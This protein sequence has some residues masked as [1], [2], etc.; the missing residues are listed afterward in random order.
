[1][2][3]IISEK[4]SEKIIILKLLKKL[5]L[6]KIG[7][8]NFEN[9]A[10]Y[11]TTTKNYKMIVTTDTIIEN[12]DFFFKDPPE[13]VAQKLVCVNLSDLAAMGSLP[14]A[15]TL[16][17]SL[18]SRIDLN[19]LKK[20]TKKLFF[21]QK[22][23]NIYLIGGDISKSKELNLSATFFGEAKLNNILS[24]NKCFVGQDIWV[25]GNLGNSYLGFKL[26]KNLKLKINK[27]DKGFFIKSYLYPNPCMFG[28]IASK[29]MSA[30]IDISDGF[31]GNLNKILN[32]KIGANINLK[33]IPIS[34]NLKRV[35]NENSSKIKMNDIINGGDDYQLIFTS[36]KKFKNKL[37]NLAKKNNIKL[38]KIGSIIKE[39]GVFD[40]SINLIKNVS[41]FDHFS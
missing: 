35:I 21:F 12:V 5:N 33:K 30:A 10:S 13:S 20:L 7:T 34:K 31:Y 26:L 29:Y 1:M 32:N 24:Q 37:I 17:L 40:D 3:K 6:N 36:D 38:S 4:L 19:W 39:K 16:N 2:K 25:T 11:L 18:P 9:D 15:Y 14:K 8:F 22:K 27:R 23:Y 28:S 41:S